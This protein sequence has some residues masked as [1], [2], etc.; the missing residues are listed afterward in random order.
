LELDLKVPF[1]DRFRIGGTDHSSLFLLPARCKEY[2]KVRMG[3]QLP[4]K[5]SE[6]LGI[7]EIH[8]F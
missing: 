1:L 2:Y 4:E 3:H 5:T 6:Y 8:Y 7:E